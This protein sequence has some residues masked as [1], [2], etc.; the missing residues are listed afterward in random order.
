MRSQSLLDTKVT[1]MGRR[2][3]HLKFLTFYLRHFLS[4]Y[5]IFA[6]NEKVCVCVCVHAC[7]FVI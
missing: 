1:K 2:F 6:Y 4:Y 7:V 5:I 3:F